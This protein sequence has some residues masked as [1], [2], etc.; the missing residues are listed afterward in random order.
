M[1]RAIIFTIFEALLFGVCLFGAA[2]KLLWPM[3]WAIL[4]TYLLFKVVGL[5][6]LDPNLI[7]ERVT[8]GPGIDRGDVVL[9]SLGCL[10]LYPAT[11]IVA[12]LD[13]VRFGH[14]LPISQS[15]QVCAFFIYVLGY[16]FTYWA[17]YSNPFFSTF[18]RIQEDRGHS[19]ISTGPYALI[20]HPGYTGVLIAHLFLPLALDSFWALLPTTLGVLIFVV[21]TS[22]E[23]QTLQEHLVG[24]REYQDQVRWR[25]LPFIW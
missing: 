20:R 6:F 18:V 5:V 23:D 13:A 15:I 1:I 3:G 7:R 10:T 22:R 17:I 19:V 24:Y 8:P 16:G 14:A 11:F 4:G 2:G 21:R 9:A 25:L 12:G